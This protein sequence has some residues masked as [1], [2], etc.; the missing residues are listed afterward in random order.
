MLG[1]IAAACCFFWRVYYW[2]ER[3]GYAWTPYG[4]FLLLGSIGSDVVYAVVYIYVHRFANP[5]D[6]RVKIEAKKSR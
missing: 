5:L 4:Q 6:T 1:T 3:F 2:P